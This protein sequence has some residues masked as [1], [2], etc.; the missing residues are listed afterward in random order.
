MNC[1]ARILFFFPEPLLPRLSFFFGQWIDRHQKTHCHQCKLSL[2]VQV[3][4]LTLPQARH[5]KHGRHQ[6]NGINEN[7]RKQSQITLGN[8]GNL[9]VKVSSHQLICCQT[10]EDKVRLKLALKCFFQNRFLQL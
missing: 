3:F 9:L 4:Q 6:D 7:L 1:T 2:E 8:Y 5:Q 10:P